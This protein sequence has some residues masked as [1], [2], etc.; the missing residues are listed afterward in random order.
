M[1][2]QSHNGICNGMV[3]CCA[4][5]RHTISVVALG[6]AAAPMVLPTPLQQHHFVDVWWTARHVL[7]CKKT[8]AQG[9]HAD[10][11]PN[12]VVLRHIPQNLR[13]TLTR[14]HKLGLHDV[15]TGYITKSTETV[16]RKFRPDFPFSGGE[17]WP[18][19]WSRFNAI[20]RSSSKYQQNSQNELPPAYQ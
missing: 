6:N 1:A 3:W 11:Q 5:R 2:G 18:T 16:L 12:T 7:L 8:L 20:N 9:I 15:R 4:R 17:F 13:V 10:R 14:I 19:C